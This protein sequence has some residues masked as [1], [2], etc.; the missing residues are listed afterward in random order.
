MKPLTRFATGLALATAVAAGTFAAGAPA[1]AAPAEVNPC[2][3]F[4]NTVCMTENS[5]SSGQ[6]WRQTPSQVIGCRTLVPDGFNDKASY[7]VNSTSGFIM[8]VFEHHNCTGEQRV[9]YPGDA[10]PLVTDSFNDK[11]S[12]IQVH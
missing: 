3:D 12:S 7:L 8:R 1:G 5:N 2:S 10:L 4:P 6:V 11:A 9:L